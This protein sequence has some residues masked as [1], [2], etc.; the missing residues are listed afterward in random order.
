MFLDQSKKSDCRID[1]EIDRK[2]L[3]LLSGEDEHESILKSSGFSCLCVCSVATTG[4]KQQA[5]KRE[6]IKA[7]YQ[8]LPYTISNT[9]VTN[10]LCEGIIE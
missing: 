1:R 10:D 9:S 8:N 5:R 7:W 4:N 3:L 6:R 2:D